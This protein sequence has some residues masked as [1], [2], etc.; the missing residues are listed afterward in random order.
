MIAAV[1]IWFFVLLS[2]DGQGGVYQFPGR[3]QCL[4]AQAQVVVAQVNGQIPPAVMIGV[5]SPHPASASPVP[6]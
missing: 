5:C 1:T 2:P 6:G 4:E 3:P